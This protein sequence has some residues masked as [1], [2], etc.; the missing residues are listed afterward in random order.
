ML[1]KVLEH[2]MRDEEGWISYWLYELD[3]GTEYTDGCVSDNGEDVCL[4]TPSDLY[5]QLVKELVNKHKH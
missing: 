5:K 3:L 4:R 2:V 1:V